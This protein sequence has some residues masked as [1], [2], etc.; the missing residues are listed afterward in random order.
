MYSKAVRIFCR[1]QSDFALAFSRVITPLHLFAISLKGRARGKRSDQNQ[2]ENKIHDMAEVL[3]NMI[4]I[5]KEKRN[6][7]TYYDATSGL[8]RYIKMD[9]EIPTLKT[10]KEGDI[11]RV[12]VSIH[13]EVCAVCPFWIKKST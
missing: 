4:I 11:H 8:C 5:G 3:V 1:F 7:C 12:V 9:V 10:V 6:L 2:L 13:P